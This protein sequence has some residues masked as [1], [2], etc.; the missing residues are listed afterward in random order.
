MTR[1]LV[2]AVVLGA[3]GGSSG[4]DEPDGAP[5]ADGHGSD[6]GGADGGGA[7]AGGAPTAAQLNGLLGSCDSIGGPYATD[8][9][10]EETVSICQLDG[11]VFWIADMDVDC[12][13]M[14]SP[15][16]SIDT[17]LDFQDE[18]AATDSNGDPLDAAT[19]PYVVVPSPSSRWHYEDSG[20]DLG[21]VVAVIYH[22][23]VEYGVIG[24]TGPV[25]IIGESSYAM[26]ATL[27]IDPDPSTG[28]TDGPVAYI[29]FSN[30]SVNPIEDHDAATTLGISRAQALL[31]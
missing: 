13:G 17:D 10:G 14:E 5:M 30:S 29:A 31:Q 24:D 18:T 25:D 15:Q 2:L 26:A 9:G 20:L 19:L 6:A 11:A 23:H 3:C 21:S 8:D 16:C 28:G 12:D 22:D 1:V 7:D 4:G 27:G